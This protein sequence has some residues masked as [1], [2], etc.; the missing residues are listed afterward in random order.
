MQHEKMRSPFFLSV[1]KKIPSPL[2][3]LS[4]SLSSDMDL[5][6][7]ALPVKKNGLADRKKKLLIIYRMGT[8]MPT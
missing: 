1:Q 3:P 7:H 4:L 6:A 8:R 2:L 5:F